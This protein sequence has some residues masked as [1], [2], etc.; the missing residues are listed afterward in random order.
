MSRLCGV[1]PQRTNAS[2]LGRLKAAGLITLAWLLYG[3]GLISPLTPSEGA[4]GILDVVIFAL[5][6]VALLTVLG[7]RLRNMA[8]RIMV[9]L[10]AGAIVTFTGWLL[11]IQRGLL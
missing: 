10:Q 7:R 5:A 9:L 8:A 4:P 6:P 2:S 1:S 3:I 11:A